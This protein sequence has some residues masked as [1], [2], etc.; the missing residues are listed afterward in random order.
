MQPSAEIPQDVFFLS[1]SR[2]TGGSAKSLVEAQ[3]HVSDC[4]RCTDFTEGFLAR[5]QKENAGTATEVE[6]KPVLFFEKREQ[7]RRKIRSELGAA[8]IE[9]VEK[10]MVPVIGDDYIDNREER[11]QVQR[12]I[13]L[14][15]EPHLDG[16][17]SSSLDSYRNVSY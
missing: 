1:Y 2:C 7:E 17:L 15:L 8:V 3:D 9:F 12:I 14:L 5:E 10:W 13:R 11:Q 16:V 6:N 4:Q